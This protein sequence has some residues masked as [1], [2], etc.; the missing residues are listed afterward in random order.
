[1]GSSR[2]KFTSG[3]DLLRICAQALQCVTV[4]RKGNDRACRAS[5]AAVTQ[6]CLPSQFWSQ[7]DLF[8]N[9][10]VI[11]INTVRKQLVLQSK[12]DALEQRML[13]KMD[14][15]LAKFLEKQLGK[16]EAVLAA[17]L[18]DVTK[19]QTCICNWK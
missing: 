5:R 18:H 12:L 9:S 7:T 10:C 13:S 2:R 1:M 17:F 14:R 16:R 19:A 8:S 6:P 4:H 11:L 15:A 3:V